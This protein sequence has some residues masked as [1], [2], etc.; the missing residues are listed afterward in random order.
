MYKLEIELGW[1]EK[2]VIE[3]NDFNKIALIQE[4]IAEQE[5]CNWEVEEDDELCFVDEDGLTWVYSPE[6][7]EW[8]VYQGE[9]EDEDDQE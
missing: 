7:D 9:E 4:F 3:T 1:D 8:V 2:I 5:E 6:L